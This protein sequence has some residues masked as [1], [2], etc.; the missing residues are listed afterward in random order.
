[1]MRGN[2]FNM[3][4]NNA[5]SYLY[6]KKGLKYLDEVYVSLKNGKKGRIDG[7]IA[8]TAIIERKA[9][10]LAKVTD[11]TAKSYI[12]DAAKYKGADMGGKVLTEKVYLQ[13]ENAKGV[14]QKVLDHATKKGV[15]IIDDIMK[16]PGL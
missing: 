6:T 2:S 7:Y 1:M 15:E 9:T 4:M 3:V 11:N 12:D 8:D 14:S 13:V 10:D 16:L 5:L